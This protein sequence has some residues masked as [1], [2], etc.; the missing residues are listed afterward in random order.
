MAVEPRGGCDPRNGIV[1]EEDLEGFVKSRRHM[2]Q[3]HAGD[4]VWA[5]CFVVRGTA[6]SLLHDSRGDAARDHRD[7]VLMIGRDAKLPRGQAT[8]IGSHVSGLAR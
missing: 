6:E 2:L 8:G 3:D 4:S 7:C 1:L 5:R